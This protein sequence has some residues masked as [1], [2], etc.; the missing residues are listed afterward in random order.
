M[1]GW[2][3]L[4]SDVNWQDYHGMWAKKARD[5]SWYVL[6]WTNLLDA[7]GEEFAD[8]P[9]ECD[10]KRV[11]L[12]E[13]PAKERASA[14]HCCGNVEVGGEVLTE[15]GHILANGANVD[16]CV[17]ECCI[18]YGLG[19]PLESF[20]GRMRPLN[21]RAKARRYAENLMRDSA[22]FGRVRYGRPIDQIL[23]GY[24]YGGR[25]GEDV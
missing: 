13:L 24:R 9:Y 5:G 10:V 3:E 2:I 12:N 20:T 7:G 21:I 4:C 17:L 1:R 16:L 8:T 25:P 15:S 19:E 23:G 14:L 22:A 11:D 6:R 18:Q